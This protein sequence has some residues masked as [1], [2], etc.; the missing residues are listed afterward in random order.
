MDILKSYEGK[1]VFIK[2]KNGRSYSGKI[3]EVENKG[4]CTLVII[5]DKFD[6]KVA[7][8]STE[9]SVIE[10]EAEK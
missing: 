10:E 5:S 8:Y 9:I 7:F 1:Q 3:L 6:K 4:S 2:L